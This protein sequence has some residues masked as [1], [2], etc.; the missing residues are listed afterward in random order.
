MIAQI[1]VLISLA[2]RDF[3]GGDRDFGE[4]CLVSV[5]KIDDSSKVLQHIGMHSHIGIEGQW[6]SEW[7]VARHYVFARRFGVGGMGEN[8]KVKTGGN[9]VFKAVFESLSGMSVSEPRTFKIGW[10]TALVAANLALTSNAA[11]TDVNKALANS[12]VK[13]L[14]TRLNPDISKPW[15]KQAPTE[16]AGSGVVIDGNRIL[17]NA[18]VAQY[19]SEVR[20]QAN[21][22]GDKLSATVE[23]IAPAI[24]LA[25][26][27]LDDE[28]FFK[29]HAPIQRASSLPAIKDTVLTYGFPT[30]GESQSI[31]KGIVSRIEFAY[32]RHHTSGLRI[33]V[34]AAINPGNS[35]GPA[36]VADKMIG[37]V[38][39]NIPTAQNIG[40]IIPNE[41]IELFLKDIADGRY[42]GK[43]GFYDSFQTLENPALRPFLMLDKDVKGMVVFKPLHSDPSYPLKKWD[44]L[45]HIGNTPVDSQG[46]VSVGDGLRLRM[47]YLTQ[48]FAS[49]GQ[50]PL[51]IIRDG[52]PM[53]VQLPVAS[54]MPILIDELLGTYPQYFIYGPM[55]ISKAV[56]E[57]LPQYQGT[58]NANANLAN[59]MV[60][61]SLVGN[62]LATQRSV[63]ATNQR[64]ELV[65]VAAPFFP[66]KLAANYSNMAMRVIKSV[67]DI[68]IR[69]LS[70]LVELL[71]DMKDEFVAFDV[72]Q[73]LGE[74]VVFRHKE[75]LSATEEI[76]S[77]NGIR[78]QGSENLMKVWQDSGKK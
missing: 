16:V 71:R 51:K 3:C 48:K 30:G 41:E 24:D 70:H 50:L 46:M 40:Y 64:E 78:S 44:V 4:Q 1:Y 67:N 54:I 15:N 73:K 63:F 23:F 18:H 10:V 65:V 9:Q 45:T 25:V 31:T 76:L 72:E 56:T 60:M 19:A 62:P 12:V 66:H 8:S 74:S 42:D 55:V 58:N 38:Y 2:N 21:E 43:P 37:L 28:I 77:K 13:V 49:N 14:A 36:I 53:D 61:W 35:G 20:I 33:Q 47:Q 27:K 69:S 17:T 39:S 26:L 34:D 57:M 75:M 68:P 5:T 52:K 32:Y 22:S 11:E 29:S 59:L 6:E 7:P